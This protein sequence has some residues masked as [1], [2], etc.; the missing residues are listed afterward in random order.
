MAK[1]QVTVVINGEE[2]VS[3]A[4]GQADSALGGFAGKVP[5]WA[6][7]IGLLTAAYQLVT[8][9]IGAAKDYVL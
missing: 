8:A 2:T 1:R 5:T 7:T 9:A 6:K 3:E 4:T